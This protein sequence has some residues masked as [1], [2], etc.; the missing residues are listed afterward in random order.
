MREFWFCTRSHARCT[1]S[2]PDLCACLWCVGPHEKGWW[3]ERFCTT[4]RDGW[5]H[6]KGPYVIQSSVFIL[7]KILKGTKCEDTYYIWF[8]TLTTRTFLTCVRWAVQ[9]KRD[10]TI[11]RTSNVRSTIS[12][13]RVRVQTTWRLSSYSAD[14][15]RCVVQGL[16]TFPWC[17]LLWMTV[18][19]VSGEATMRYISLPTFVW[20]FNHLSFSNYLFHTAFV[21]PHFPVGVYVVI[22][23]G[24]S[25]HLR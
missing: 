5:K 19:D 25:L 9:L 6:H 20:R 4:T 8:Y 21:L 15:L 22:G 10:P 3:W 24:M 14:L 17:I 16:L 1:Q 7:C 18:M 13:Y 2:C 23:V 12:R 11:L